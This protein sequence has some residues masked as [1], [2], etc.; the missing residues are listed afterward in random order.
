MRSLSGSGRAFS[1]FW[2]S[3]FRIF[4]PITVGSGSNKCSL[5]PYAAR[6]ASSVVRLGLSLCTS[7][8]AGNVHFGALRNKSSLYC[9]RRGAEEPILE[10]ELIRHACPIGHGGGGY[11]PKGHALP[12]SANAARN[13]YLWPWLT[14]TWLLAPISGLA[15]KRLSFRIMITKLQ[16]HSFEYSDDSGTQ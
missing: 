14:G 3:H 9:C 7:L 6:A 8:I 4:P 16:G 15:G 11:G 2:Q 10:G 5:T 13:L 12:R 1:E